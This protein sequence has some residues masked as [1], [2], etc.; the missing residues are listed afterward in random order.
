MVHIRSGQWWAD[1][2]DVEREAY[3]GP[4]KLQETLMGGMAYLWEHA[5]ETGTLGLR[6]L[7]NVDP[8]SDEENLN[9]RRESCG[10][11]FFRNLEDLEKWSSRHPS[12]LKIFNGAHKHARDF[13]EGKRF[14]TWHEVSVLKEGEGR[15]EYVNCVPETGVVRWVGLEREVLEMDGEADGQRVR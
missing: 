4:G 2:D 7:F 14:M 9:L 1:C 11:G 12:H 8:G 5:R 15:F 3:E 10:A 13:G 6:F